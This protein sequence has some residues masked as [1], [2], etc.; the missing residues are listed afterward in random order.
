M[1]EHGIQVFDLYFV[2]DVSVV[3][4]RHRPLSEFILQRAIDERVFF[5]FLEAEVLQNEATFF[6]LIVILYILHLVVHRPLDDSL[7]GVFLLL[8][9]F[10]FHLLYTFNLEHF[11]Y[12]LI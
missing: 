10:L 8:D 4:H 2:L 12:I 3:Q 7:D 11:I 1:D 6:V 5:A 9:L